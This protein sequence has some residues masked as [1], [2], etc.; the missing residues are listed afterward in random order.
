[1]QLLTALTDAGKDADLRIY[2]QGEHGAFY[3][4]E[5]FLLA[6]NVQ[7]Q[8]LERYLKGNCD[9]PSLNGN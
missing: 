1:M 6:E 5:S 8:Y 4:L 2:P 7:F 9:L 3:S